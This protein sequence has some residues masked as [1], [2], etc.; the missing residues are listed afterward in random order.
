MVY[1]ERSCIK[2]TKVDYTKQEEET[3]SERFTKGQ[4]GLMALGVVG[5][6]MG[7][8]G[9]AR[10][11]RFGYAIGNRTGIVTAQQQYIE[12]TKAIAEEVRKSEGE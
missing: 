5:T 9:F 10:G 11:Y 7:I 4:L 2:M 12:A 6:G 3:K 8:F 1:Y